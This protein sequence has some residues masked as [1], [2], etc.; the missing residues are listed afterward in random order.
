M[1]GGKKGREK[2]KAK[3]EG[4]KGREKGKGKG[5]GKREGKKGK[6]YSWIQPRTYLFN[7]EK[8]HFRDFSQTKLQ[9][10]EGLT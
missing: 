4:K 10:D 8:E 3:M 6:A 2:G 7:V 1:R 5:K 9:L